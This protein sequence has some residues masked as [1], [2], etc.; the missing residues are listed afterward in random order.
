MWE[1][2]FFTVSF[3]SL[4]VFFNF[5]LQNVLREVGRKVVMGPVFSM[6]RGFK[7]HLCL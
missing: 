3:T 1:K 5:S 6:D 4:N 2:M 7:A